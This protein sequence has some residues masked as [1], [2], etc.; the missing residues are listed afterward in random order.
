MSLRLKYGVSQVTPS[1]WFYILQKRQQR[2]LGKQGDAT[3]KGTKNVRFETVYLWGGRG[4][5]SGE[6]HPG[7]QAC[8]RVPSHERGA[9]PTGSRGVCC[10][11]LSALPTLLLL[12]FHL[13]CFPPAFYLS[14]SGG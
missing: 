3:T 10:H 5:L 7:V 12:R 9:E 11:R 13:T 14:F 8:S 2:L 1:Y 4:H 6:K